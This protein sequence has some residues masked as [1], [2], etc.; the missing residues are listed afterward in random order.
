MEH[1]GATDVDV[2]LEGKALKTQF[3]LKDKTSI[4]IVESHLHELEQRLT[5][6]G[7]SVTVNTRMMLDDTN[8]NAFMNVLETDKPQISIKRYSF[9]VR[10]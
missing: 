8:E 9:D 5:K 2:L 6:R 3:S 4:A 7:F 10:A 1:L